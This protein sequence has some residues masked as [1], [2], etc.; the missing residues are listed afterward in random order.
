MIKIEFGIIENIQRDK[1][2]SSYEPEK[3]NCVV[4]DDDLYINDWWEKLILMKTYFHNLNE[5]N[6][7]L[8][9]WGVT[10]IPP[11]SLPYFQE[12]VISDKRIKKDH[13][14][15]DLANKIQDAIERQKYM[16]HFGV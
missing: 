6:Y 15:V 7:G 13:H 4:I 9:R 8:A 1:D 2:Y 14:L 5:P 12:I 10:L 11:E 3:Y 16:I